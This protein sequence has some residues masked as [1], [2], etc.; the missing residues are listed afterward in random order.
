MH[1]CLSF[2]SLLLLNKTRPKLYRKMEKAFLFVRFSERLFQ[3]KSHVRSMLTKQKLAAS[4]TLIYF[5]LY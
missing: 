1:I 5:F 4:V 2:V 3:K